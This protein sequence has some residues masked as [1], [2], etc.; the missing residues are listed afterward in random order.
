MVTDHPNHPGPGE[1]GDPAT[2]IIARAL[3]RRIADVVTTP[4]TKRTAL[5][6]VRA[7][8][9]LTVSFF[10]FWIAQ[11]ISALVYW[12]RGHRPE[13]HVGRDGFIWTVTIAAILLLIAA[14]VWHVP[15]WR[16]LSSVRLPAGRKGTTGYLLRHS[17]EGLAGPINLA[18]G[19]PP[20]H[21]WS[22]AVLYSGVAPF[23]SAWPAFALSVLTLLVLVTGAVQRRSARKK[24][25]R[26]KALTP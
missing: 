5:Y 26:E 10:G 14:L 21:F 8:V 17:H 13:D 12:L 3:H 1:G 2:S 6:P 22:V 7:Y 25:A 24:S 16:G 18:G 9:L 20:P 11:G 19:S 15:Q 4:E 23:V